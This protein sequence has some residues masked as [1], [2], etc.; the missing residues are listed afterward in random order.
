V[1]TLF[2]LCS[3]SGLR[4][5]LRAQ[6][7]ARALEGT[8]EVRT[9]PLSSPSGYPFKEAQLPGTLTDPE[10]MERRRTVCDIGALRTLYRQED[11]GLG[12][13]CPAEP[14]EHY[15]RKGGAAEETEG[16]R[17]LCNALT[18]TVDVG[19]VRPRDGYTEP[20]LLTLGSDL[21][22]LREVTSGEPYTA[23]DAIAYL[24]S[25]DAPAGCR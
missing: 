2:A 8:L 9:N 19:Q 24:L 5:D 13:R 14:V 6:A 18:A 7:L 4:E 20:P 17:C 1:G 22:F 12:Y 21:R 15:L 10:V 25:E 3:E 23:A 11:G 16:R